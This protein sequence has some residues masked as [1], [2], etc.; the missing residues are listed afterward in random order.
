MSLHCGGELAEQNECKMRVFYSFFFLVTTHRHMSANGERSER[1]AEKI[2]SRQTLSEPATAKLR[3]ADSGKPKLLIQLEHH[4]AKQLA[5]LPKHSAHPA[6]LRLPVYK[7]VFGMYGIV[8]TTPRSHF[9]RSP[10]KW[11]FFISRHSCRDK[12]RV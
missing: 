4:L 2:D 8:R 12:A 9:S 3:L 7:E 11:L 10:H 1:W 5:T 6:I